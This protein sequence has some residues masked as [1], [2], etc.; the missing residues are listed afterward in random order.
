MRADGAG[1]GAIK[2]IDMPPCEKHTFLID[3]CCSLSHCCALLKFAAR[4]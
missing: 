2:S 3:V 1:G 4:L